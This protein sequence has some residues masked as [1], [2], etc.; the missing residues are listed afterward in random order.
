MITYTTANST[1]DLESILTLQKEN[2]PQNLDEAEIQS[3]GFVTV[4]HSF[5]LLKKMNGIEP[6]II[7]KDGEKI[8]GYVLAM[9]KNARNDIPVL[10]PMFDLF[11]K[12]FYK[13]QKIADCNYILVGQVCIGKA[14]RG[15]GIFDDCYN[16]YREFYKGKYDMAI[17]EIASL[18]PRSVNAHK[19]VGF[20]EIHTYTAP[21]NTEWKIV[22]WD[23]RNNL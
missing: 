15:T 21:D 6:H 7:A 5:E 20:E 1:I 22:V 8:A 16:F 14:Y 2:L 4:N 11:E 13:G 23:W 12:I 10:I 18:N 3:Q 19:R 9:T 17:T